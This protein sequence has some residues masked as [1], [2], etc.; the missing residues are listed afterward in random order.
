MTKSKMSISQKRNASEIER[1]SILKAQASKKQFIRVTTPEYLDG[2]AKKN[3]DTTFQ[4]RIRRMG[5]GFY[6]S[7]P[8]RAYAKIYKQFPLKTT[9]LM[10][11]GKDE[12]IITKMPE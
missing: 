11:L 7:M 12:I 4:T 1:S 2:V 3:N 5:V 6:V 8:V 10:R 9:F